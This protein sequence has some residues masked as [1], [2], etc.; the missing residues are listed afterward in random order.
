MASFLLCLLSMSYAAS[1]LA[2]WGN[3]LMIMFILR[4]SGGGRISSRVSSGLSLFGDLI[5]VL[6]FFFSSLSTR[7]GSLLGGI[8]R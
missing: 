5:S 3:P 6:S 8:L 1:T 2:M 4:R 7:V